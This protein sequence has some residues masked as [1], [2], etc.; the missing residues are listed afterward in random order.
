MVFRENSCL[1]GII[2]YLFIHQILPLLTTVRVGHLQSP[3]GPSRLPDCK[4]K[5]RICTLWLLHPRFTNSFSV[6]GWGRLWKPPSTSQYESFQ[7]VIPSLSASPTSL[8]PISRVL[9]FPINTTPIRTRPVIKE[10]NLSL[11]FSSFPFPSLWWMIKRGILFSDVNCFTFAL[12]LQRS[13]F[14]MIAE[15]TG[16]KQCSASSTQWEFGQWLLYRCQSFFYVMHSYGFIS[17]ITNNSSSLSNY[18]V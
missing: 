6:Q 13:V 3:I 18:I 2:Q 12:A 9:Q 11:P 15:F 17:K 8:L 7:N 1:R 16:Y 4:T 10:Q 14:E 5:I